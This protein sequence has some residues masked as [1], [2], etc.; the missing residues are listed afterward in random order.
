MMHTLQQTICGLP[1][2]FVGEGPNRGKDEGVRQS[3]GHLAAL[4]GQVH[5][6]AGC[7]DKEED[8]RIQE[9]ERIHHGQRYELN[10]DY[11]FSTKGGMD[12]KA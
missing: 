1:H 2:H 4:G 3:D 9:H 10:A 11:Y 7:Q 5:E 12:A 8:K 6:H